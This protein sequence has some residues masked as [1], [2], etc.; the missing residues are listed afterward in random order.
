[1]ANFSK[2]INSGFNGAAF[3]SIGMIVTQQINSGIHFAVIF[4]AVVIGS[5]FP[6]ID[7]DYGVP[8]RFLWGFVSAFAV[9]FLFSHG[10]GADVYELI[11]PLLPKEKPFNISIGLCQSIVSTAFYMLVFIFIYGY[12]R[13]D[14]P[15]FFSARHLFMRWSIHRGITHSILGVILAYSASYWML[16]HIGYAEPKKAASAFIFG[17]LIHLM[18]DMRKHS[19]NNAGEF[20]SRKHD[21]FPLK[22]L[23]LRWYNNAAAAVLVVVIW[24]DLLR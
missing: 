14:M 12:E 5:I 20:H 9:Y 16:Q 10:V 13:N 17:W 21:M 11:Q 24:F 6:D 15:I 18:L 8:L 2:H 19:G 7:S 3:L 1:M 4:S 22:L 23:G